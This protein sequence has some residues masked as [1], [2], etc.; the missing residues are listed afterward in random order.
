MVRRSRQGM[1]KLAVQI[2]SGAGFSF[3][4]IDPD[5]EVQIKRFILPVGFT[6]NGVVKVSIL[7]QP[8]SHTPVIADTLDSAY[9]LWT[10]VV[11]ANSTLM[12]DRPFTIRL[13]KSER[14]VITA[15]VGDLLEGTLWMHFLEL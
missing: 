15:E 8:V 11:T 14:I 10:G 5:D 7:K 4:V 2:P 13:M 1:Q 9:H 12:L 3:A 6:G